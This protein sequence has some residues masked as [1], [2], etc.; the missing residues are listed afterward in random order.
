M[1]GTTIFKVTESNEMCT[2][3]F[4]SVISFLLLKLTN[5]HFIYTVPMNSVTSEKTK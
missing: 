2:F 1:D 3:I 4:I 5:L